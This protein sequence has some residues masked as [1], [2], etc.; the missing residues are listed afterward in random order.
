MTNYVTKSTNIWTGVVEDTKDP[1]NLGRCKVRVFG[2]HSDNLREVPTSTLPWAMSIYSPNTGKSFSTLVEGDYVIGYFQDGEA[3]QVPVIIG[4]TPGILAQA[5]NKARGFSPQSKDP[6]KTDLPA[7]QSHGSVTTPPSARGDIANTSIFYTNK[8]TDHACDFRYQINLDVGLDTFINP[9]TAIQSAI[10]AGKNKAAMQMR[11]ESAQKKIAKGKSLT[12]S[13]QEA[14]TLMERQAGRTFAAPQDEALRLAQERAALPVEQG[15]LGLPPNN[16]AEQRAAAMGAIDYLHGTERLDRLLAKK[17]LDPRKATSGPMP[18]GTNSPELASNYA[19]SKADT[20]LSAMDTGELA[21]YFQVFPQAMGQRG[22]VPRSVESVWYSLPLDKKAE[23][24]D[25]AKR[26]GYQ[27]FDQAEGPLTLPPP[28]VNAMNVGEDTWNY[29]LNKES[30]GNPLAALK[31]IWAE[32]GALYNQEEKLADI[33]KLAGFPY[34]ISQSNAPW[35]SAQ[36]VLLGKARITN[37]LVSTNTD[38]LQTKVIPALEEVFKN[39]RT[40][41]KT[42]GADQW[43]KNTRYTP[44]QWLEQLKQDTDK[45]EN[46]YVW[47]SIPDKVTK[48]LEKLGYNGIIDTGGKGGGIGHEV[49]IPF[50]PEQLRSKFAAFDPMKVNKPDL[51]AGS[52]AIPMVADED[53][54]RDMLEK[55]FNNQ[56]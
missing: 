51:L 2:V 54:R 3:S 34:Q 47:T 7:G 52:I 44:K 49:V 16:T 21:N 13:E 11:Y 20:S 35:S 31:K 15:G 25:K 43:D 10:K 8:V 32:S 39:D 28:V 36:G 42:G 29:Y 17:N 38:E 45:G 24:L 12:N 9:V 46:S 53:S 4:I 5:Y 40:R 41:V 55:L 27:N 6:I 48:Q 56:K 30:K 18:Y 1:L 37:P 50:K 14:V 33:Y 19:M 22:S 26:V 23:I